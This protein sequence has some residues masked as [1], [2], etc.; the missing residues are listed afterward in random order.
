M[1]RAATIQENTAPGVQYLGEHAF[2]RAITVQEDT[3]LGGQYAEELCNGRPLS[4]RTLY[5]VA[6]FQE[7]TLL[8][9]HYSE[10]CNQATIQEAAIQKNTLPGRLLACGHSQEEY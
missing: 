5:K 9:G 2:Y 4:R 10:N 1:Y 6:A 7:D 3:L 8:G